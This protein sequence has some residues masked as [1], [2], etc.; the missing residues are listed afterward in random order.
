M[1]AGI[2][3]FIHSQACWH[4]I[5]IVFTDVFMPRWKMRRPGTGIGQSNKMPG[6]NISMHPAKSFIFWQRWLFYSSILFAVC[7][8]LFALADGYT[9]D[10]YNVYLG[11]RLGAEQMTPETR[12]LVSFL[13]GP[14]GGTMACSYILLAY[15]T[16]IPFSKRELW[17]RDAIV[18]SF[19]AWIILDTA[20][21]IYYGIYLQV[22]LNVFSLLV[23]AIPL[24]VTWKYFNTGTTVSKSPAEVAYLKN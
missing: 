9:F 2:L 1:P 18:V 6:M 7:S 14:M 5:F 22:A 3:F 10:F 15:I 13:R 12:K 21:C 8:I 11:R 16:A 20:A 23:K 4:M 24:T 17:S 19:G